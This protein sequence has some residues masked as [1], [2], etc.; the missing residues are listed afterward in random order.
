[1]TNRFNFSKRLDPF[2]K[3]ILSLRF[4]QIK[5]AEKILINRLVEKITQLFL[6][7]K[8]YPLEA[9]NILIRT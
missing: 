8:K 5:E 2:Q 4:R 6:E 9:K 7:L 3:I 1:M